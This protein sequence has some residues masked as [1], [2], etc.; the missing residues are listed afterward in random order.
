VAR[1][2][3]AARSRDPRAWQGLTSRATADEALVDR[4]AQP[5]AARGKPIA[6]VI[7]ARHFCVAT[8]ERTLSQRVTPGR[9][10]CSRPEAP[11]VVAARRRSAAGGTAHRARARHTW[12]SLLTYTSCTGWCSER[13]STVRW[14]RTSV[15]AR[16]SLRFTDNA[17]DAGGLRA[18]RCAAAHDSRHRPPDVDRLGRPVRAGRP[19][20][21]SA[22][23]AR[24]CFS[25]P[26][27][28]AIRAAR[29]ASRPAPR[30]RV[31]RR[32]QSV[33]CLIHDGAAIPSQH[34]A[35]PRGRDTFDD[36]ARTSDCTRRCRAR[37]RCSRPTTT[38]RSDLSTQLRHR[39]R[40]G[41][42]PAAGLVSTPR[43][44]IARCMASTVARDRPGIGIA[45]DGSASA[46]NA[47]CGAASS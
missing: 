29:P 39:A 19:P 30:C 10:S 16:A 38:A 3:C 34:R 17:A 21:C 18:R 36:I 40:S 2:L 32:A 12:A 6:D 43:T 22:A 27:P 46:T 33:F 11:S 26:M 28:S 37:R 42:R 20:A 31:R 41:R 45:L 14:V 4:L 44:K 8:P 9:P 13:G 15:T 47:R 1:M 24:L 35:G 7:D 5:Q 25:F 23:R